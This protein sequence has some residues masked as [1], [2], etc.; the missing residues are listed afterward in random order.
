MSEGVW[1][2]S[3]LQSVQIVSGVEHPAHYS[4]DGGGGNLSPE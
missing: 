2:L 3:L 1:D 4:T